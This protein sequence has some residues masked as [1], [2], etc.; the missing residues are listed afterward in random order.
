M[1]INNNYPFSKATP[2]LWTNIFLIDPNKSQKTVANEATQPTSR[3][4]LRNISMPKES[5]IKQNQLC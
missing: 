4:A 5:P 3:W 2:Y 1:I